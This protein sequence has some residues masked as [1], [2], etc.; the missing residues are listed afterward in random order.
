MALQFKSCSV[1]GC[2]GNAAKGGRGWCPSHWHRWQRHG[3]PLK[4]GPSQIRRTGCSV[5]GCDMPHY[6]RGYCRRHWERW[7]AH[8]DPLGGALGPIAAREYLETVV[9][10]YDGDECLTWP[11]SRDEHGYAQI[12]IDRRR[13]KVSRYVCA[14]RHGE[15]PTPKHQAAHSCGRGHLGCVTGCHLSWKTRA[16]NEADKLLHGTHNRGARH[17]MSKLTDRDVAEIRSLRGIVTQ[18]EIAAKF[19]VSKG[20]IREILAGR[21]WSHL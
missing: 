17:G 7:K 3:D 21:S 14:R 2:N 16:Q 9:L 6:S 12:D 11:Y 13:H 4:G 18:K 19:G 1:E 15:P 5:D 10:P 20:H 8:G